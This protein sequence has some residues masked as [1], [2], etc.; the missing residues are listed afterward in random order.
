SVEITRVTGLLAGVQDLGEPF[1]RMKKKPCARR[2]RKKGVVEPR[3]TMNR[4]YQRGSDGTVPVQNLEG[5]PFRGLDRGELDLGARGGRG[6]PEI[7]VNEA[8]APGY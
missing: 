4:E 3:D 2:V 1:K 5:E 8:R 6:A 7:A